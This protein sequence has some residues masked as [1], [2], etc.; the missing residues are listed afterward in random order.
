MVFFI[1]ICFLGL[2]AFNVNGLKVED[3]VQVQVYYES[4]CPYSIDFIVN[5]LYPGFLTIGSDKINLELI[6]YGHATESLINGTKTFKC[7]HG[8]AECYGNKIHSCVI[9][10]YDVNSS[11][12]FI[13]CAE[14]SDSPTDD[15]NLQICARNTNGISW[16]EIEECMSS[17]KGDDLLSE[18][19]KKTALVNPLGVPYIVF[20]G[21]YSDKN[22]NAAQTDFRKFVCDL[23]GNP[24]TEC[25][26]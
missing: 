7:Q 9:D 3:R 5:Q 6:P 15:S 19:G 26:I 10:L 24:S 8:P 14:G 21:V 18:N 25:N 12:Q 17:G 23:S 4:L 20:D 11:T 22:Q 2:Y 1:T 13:F 16:S